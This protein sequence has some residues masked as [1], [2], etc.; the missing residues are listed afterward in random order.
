MLATQEKMLQKMLT[1]LNR[2]DASDQP[3]H[4]HFQSIAKIEAQVGK[5]AMSKDDRDCD[6]ASTT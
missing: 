6:H 1:T 3:L 4:S 2:M 5:I